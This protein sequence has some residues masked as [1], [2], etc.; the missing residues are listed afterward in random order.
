MLNFI[1]LYGDKF[2]L[3]INYDLKTD[4]NKSKISKY[5]YTELESLVSKIDLRL[6][7]PWERK[8]LRFSGSIF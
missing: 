6:L 5:E 4:Y 8:Y 1:Y 3:L 2:D 7:S